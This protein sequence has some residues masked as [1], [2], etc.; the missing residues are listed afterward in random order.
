MDPFAGPQNPEVRSKSFLIVGI[1]ALLFMAFL[2]GADPSF[3]YLF[4]SISLVAFFF[5]LW[6]NRDRVRMPDPPREVADD[7]R[8]IFR[9]KPS[10]GRYVKPGQN[11]HKDPKV[12]VVASLFI[13]GNLIV[14]L[15][16]V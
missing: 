8:T 2:W 13:L 9:Q 15:M 14:I 10:T 12:I 7:V 11:A 6:N 5:V 4:G 3:R 16:S 1:V